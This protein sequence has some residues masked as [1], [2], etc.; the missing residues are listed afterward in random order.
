MGVKPVEIVAKALL[1]EVV[2][3]VFSAPGDLAVF[4][5]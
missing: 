2:G 3:V 4:I 1:K 5:T